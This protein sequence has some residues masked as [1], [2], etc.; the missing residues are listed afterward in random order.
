MEDDIELCVKTCHIYQVD[1]TEHKKEA[2]LLPPLPIPEWSWLSVAAKL[3]YKNV[4][5][6]FGVPADI[7]CYN[8]HKS[9][10]TDMSPFEIVL[11]RQPMTPLDVAKTKNQGKC[12][13]H[14]GSQGTDL[15]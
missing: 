12:Q 5:K 11:G 15:K 3:F 4:V 2:G 13:Q 8:F 7:F 10:A 14:T 9:A 1:K 6:Y